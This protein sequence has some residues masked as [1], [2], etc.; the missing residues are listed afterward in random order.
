[1]IRR[2]WWLI[3][4]AVLWSCSKTDEEPLQAAVKKVLPGEWLSGID[5]SADGVMLA[6]GGIPNQEGKILRST[7]QGATWSVMVAHPSKCFYFVRFIS[8]TTAFAGGDYLE[9]WRTTDA[10]LHW[11]F[12]PLD[13]NVPTNEVDRPAFRNMA[14]QGQRLVMPGGD[15][16]KKGVCYVSSDGGQSWQFTQMYHQMAG[17]GFSSS[18]NAL[19]C[20][21]GYLGR[22]SA[23]ELQ[24]EMIDYRGDFFTSVV[25]TGSREA[26]MSGYTGNIYRSTD[27]GQTWDK[28]FSD[29]RCRFNQLMMNGNNII[30]LSDDGL[31][32][33]RKIAGGSWTLESLPVSSRLLHMV[34]DTSGRLL[35]VTSAGELVIVAAGTL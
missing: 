28:E 16:A 23:G 30:A 2:S 6:C 25:Y 5:V 33:R 32:A 31:L 10:G 14:V 7:D 15:Y 27:D 13:D 17:A 9:L 18:G 22:I 26:L 11:R 20:G 3:L 35:A 34:A 29:G 12:Y 24:T 21:W 1:M 19:A 4:L 8:S